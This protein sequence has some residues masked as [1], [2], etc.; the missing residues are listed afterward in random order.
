MPKK[1]LQKGAR[2]SMKKVTVEMEEML[3]RRLKMKAAEEGTT[4][5]AI[6]TRAVQAELEKGGKKANT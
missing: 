3:A 1:L 5:A 6:V 2:P 4:V